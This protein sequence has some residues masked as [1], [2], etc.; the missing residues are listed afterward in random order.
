MNVCSRSAP[1]QL[2]YPARDPNPNSKQAQET[3]SCTVGTGSAEEELIHTVTVQHTSDSWVSHPACA[4]RGTSVQEHQEYPGDICWQATLGQ[5]SLE[6]TPAITGM[7]LLEPKF[8]FWTYEA[9]TALNIPLPTAAMGSTI[10]VRAL[11]H[12]SLTSTLV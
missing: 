1:H 8:I 3:G 9:H 10:R 7:I 12:N 4:T 11:P 6:H 2:S 5:H